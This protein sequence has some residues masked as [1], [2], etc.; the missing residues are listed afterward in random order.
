MEFLAYARG[1]EFTSAPDYNKIIGLF[2]SAKR[3]AGFDISTDNM[4]WSK[5][6]EKERK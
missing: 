2:E 5:I 3:Q 1:L 4:C 6:L